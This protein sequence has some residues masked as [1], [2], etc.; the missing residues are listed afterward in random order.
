MALHM[1]RALRTYLSNYHKPG[2]RLLSA[3]LHTRVTKSL[4]SC[5]W[6]RPCN[7]LPFFY[8]PLSKH[9]W[10]LKQ[11]ENLPGTSQEPLFI[12]LQLSDHCNFLHIEQR[13]WYFFQP[14]TFK[15]VFLALTTSSCCLQ[16]YFIVRKGGVMAKSGL[17][18][19]AFLLFA[20]NLTSA[21][22]FP[23]LP[24]N[25][26]PLSCL[27]PI[28]QVSSLFNFLFLFNLFHLCVWFQ[29]FPFSAQWS[30]H[31]QAFHLRYCSKLIWPR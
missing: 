19:H 25:T 20:I 2:H 3:R 18:S 24:V 8:H 21:Y 13:T 23:A 6:N 4:F 31:R 26:T 16:L 22:T 9:R 17:R 1:R 14:H 12:K 10:T 11:H 7:T 5:W 30:S 27:A 15:L 29:S 28:L